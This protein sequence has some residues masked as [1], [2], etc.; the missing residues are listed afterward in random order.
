M[1]PLLFVIILVVS[2]LVLVLMI[3][4][5]NVHPVLALLLTAIGMGVSFG[6]SLLETIELINEGFGATIASV[7]LTIIL[8]AIL[9]MGIQDTRAAD[10]IAHF[11][12]KLFKGKRLELAPSLTGFI[13]SIPV[14]GD[15]AM[16]LLAPIASRM[17]HLHK[18]SMSTMATFTGLALIVTHALVPPTPGILAA[19]LSVGADLGFVIFWGVILSIIAFFGTWLIMKKWVAK[20]FIVPLEKFTEDIGHASAK[21]KFPPAFIAFMPLVLPVIFISS[22]SF[23]DAYMAE[24]SWIH[25]VLTTMGDRVVALLIGVIFV[26]M[27]A[28]LYKQNVRAS[29]IKNSSDID[30][31]TSFHKIIFNI[32]ISRGL[33]IAILP[34]LI[35]AM[36]GAM[37]DIASSMDSAEKLANMIAETNIIPI[38]IP[39]FIA[40]ILMTFIGSITTS[41]IAATAITSPMMGVLGLSP[42]VLVLA[43]GAGTLTLIF[44]NNSGFWVMSQFFNLTTK[45]GIKYVS[46]PPAMASVIAIITLIIFDS[47]GIV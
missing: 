29:A 20:E 42:E 2:L 5:L 16:V 33:V 36:S 9:A 24:G 10:S 1:D 44:L 30:N 21:V 22:A 18:I 26:M 47:I 4:K 17:A 31:D 40:V 15:V 37:A 12:N 32:W 41:A 45:Q 43:A 34:L 7:G 14:F 23:A 6:Y 27:L 8:G 3:V 25:T 19:S 46:L 38:L 11:F 28:F 39:Y 13:I 35:T